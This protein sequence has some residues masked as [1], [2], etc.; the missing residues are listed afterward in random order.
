MFTIN[1][2]SH[3]CGCYL[4]FL[5]GDEVIDTAFRAEV[6]HHQQV[7]PNYVYRQSDLHPQDYPVGVLLA[8][9]ACQI[10]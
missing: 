8:F 5:S 10:Y 1:R 6:L 2:I 4:L 9:Q 3:K 7:P